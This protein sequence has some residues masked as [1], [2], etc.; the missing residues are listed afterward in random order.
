M[1][2]PPTYKPAGH[3][4]LA[5]YLAVNGAAST[6]SFLQQVFN[7]Q[8]LT[9]HDAPEGRVG[10]AELR[11]G[12]TVL[13]LSDAMPGWPAVPAHVHV[14]VPDV[15][16]TYARA[17]AAGAA[18]VQAP[19]RKEGDADMRG[20]FSD[21]GGTTWWVATQQG[22]EPPTTALARWHACVKARSSAGLHGLLADEVVFHSPVVHTPVSG[23]AM[24]LR[25]LHAALQVFGRPDFTYVREIV[26]AQDAMLEF[27]LELDGIRING[28]DILRWNA[29]GQITDFKVMLRPLKAV[30]KIHEQMAAL[31][32]AAA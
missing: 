7:A 6:I 32:A 3:T 25:Y 18:A 10:H 2:M 4:A 15:Q 20:G 13:M 30:H 23:K 19:V 14:Y 27:T 16:A 24:V 1:R 11:V 17:I 29:A 8:L 22:D 12:D 21:A 9:R 5:P 31:L 28:V 26:G